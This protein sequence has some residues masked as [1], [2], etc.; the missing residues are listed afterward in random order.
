MTE[1]RARPVK[2]LGSAAATITF[3]NLISRILGFVRVLATAG[4]L[5]IAALGDTYQRTNQVSNLLFEL[6]AGGMLFAVLVPTFVSH[7]ASNSRADAG[8]L[9]GAVA[10]R[11]VAAL[12]VVVIVGLAFAEP[13]VRALSSGVSDTSRD[14]Q[15][16]L[17]VFLLWFVLPQLF[18]YGL[19]A[20]ASAL[21]QA[22][23]RFVAVSVAPAASSLVVTATMVAFAF[24]HDVDRGLTLTGGEKVLL[25]GGTLAATAVLALVPLVAAARAGFPLR[26]AWHVPGDELAPLIRRGAWAT[27]HVG[28]NQVLVMSTV[29]LA[30]RI[31][32]GVIAYQT[33]F[34]FFLLPHALLA[35]PIFTSLYPRLS[36]AGAD[37]KDME[38]FS[39]DLGRGLR[40]MTALVLP[41][42]SLLAVLGGPALSL[43]RV[44]S[45]DSNG[46]S[47]VASTLAAYLAGLAAYSA[48]FLLTRASYALDDAR[49]P[50][51]VNL[52]A[53][54]VAVAA[55]TAAS[56]TFEGRALLVAFGMITAVTTT[57]AAVILH[58]HVTSLIG[59]PVPVLRSAVGSLVVAAV[60]GSAALVIVGLVG[61]A[62]SGSAVLALLGGA[63]AGSVG[64]AVAISV[65]GTD[66]VEPV[67]GIL[68]RVRGRLR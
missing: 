15:V 14:A 39:D 52:W 11:A 59:R 36:A 35:H 9:A 41:A 53:T 24:T 33:A 25:G 67:L 64:I 47:L 21:L 27:G 42:S 10:T 6:L 48:T 54:I 66:D 57:A 26:P 5:G 38:A 49:R 13:I 22:D 58:H 12:T 34:T 65:V 20:V 56:S 4:A 17:G 30:G 2:G 43:V 50:T 40:T 16:D 51:T 3:W 29:V 37:R 44:G 23:S 32:G 68:R 60:G 46:V 62:D 63:G 55:M 8:R 61:W 45:F 7:L 18:F 1:T 19:G 28:L 31:E